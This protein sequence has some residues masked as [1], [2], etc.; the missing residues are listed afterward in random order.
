[1]LRKMIAAL[2]FVLLSAGALAETTPEPLLEAEESAAFVEMMF[3]AAAGVTKESEWAYRE[4]MT[5]EQRLARNE[6]CAAYRARTLPWLIAALTPYP[7]PEAAPTPTPTPCPTPEP[8][9]ITYT[10]SDSWAAFYET[11]LGSA[12]AAKLAALGAQDEESALALSRRVTQEWL[13]QIDHEKL[14]EMNGDYLLWLYAPGTQIDYPVVQDEGNDYYLNHLFNRERNAAG[15]LFADYR[16]QAQL[17]DPNTILYGHHM[18]N[19]SMFGTLT[20]YEDQEYY[21]GNPYMLV[22]SEEEIAL[23]D[24]FA[25]YTT[26][27]SDHCYD[28]AITGEENMAYFVRKAKEKSDVSSSVE[29]THEDRIVTL[30]TCAYDFENARYVVLTRVHSVWTKPAEWMAQA[31]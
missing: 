1:M 7:D 31:Q 28:L 27:S 15:T 20:D 4:G 3:R 24:V 10:T 6:E 2:L 14:R 23:L 12:Y 18:R 30:S 22:M 8:G 29:V 9:E 11:E 17:L 5:L 19:D 25:C 21:E 26:D 13:A 16:N